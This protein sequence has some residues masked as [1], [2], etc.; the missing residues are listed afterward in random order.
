MSFATNLRNY[1]AAAGFSAK[2]FSIKLGIPY[3]TYTAYENEN[4][5]REPKYSTLCTIARALHLTPNDL[6]GFSDIADDPYLAKIRAASAAAAAAAASSLGLNP[7]DDADDADLI[8]NK[9]RALLDPV[10]FFIKKDPDTR[11]DP[12]FGDAILIIASSKIVSKDFL[13]R[14]Y[15]LASRIRQGV[16]HHA[17]LSFKSYITQHYYPDFV[18]SDDTSFMTTMYEN[19]F[20]SQIAPLSASVI[21]DIVTGKAPNPMIKN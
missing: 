4:T 1:R 19:M 10:G 20:D 5:A 3:P 11:P 21:K 14:A 12:K 13:Y 15:L 9:L 18:Q 16:D 2:D 6:L 7:T 17:D 8:F